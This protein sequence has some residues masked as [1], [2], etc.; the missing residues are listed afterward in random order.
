LSHKNLSLGTEDSGNGHLPGV[1]RQLVFL[2]QP[3]FEVL[4][5]EVPEQHL[6]ART[7]TKHALKIKFSSR[8]CASVECAP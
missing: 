6:R 8:F 3:V 1:F 2:H 5:G 4:D 7:A